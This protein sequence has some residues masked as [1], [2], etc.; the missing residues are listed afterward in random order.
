MPNSQIQFFQRLRPNVVQLWLCA[1]LG[2]VRARKDCADESMVFI[3][4]F[5]ATRLWSR[6]GFY[7]PKHAVYIGHKMTRGFN[8]NDKS[9]TWRCLCKRTLGLI[10]LEWVIAVC[11]LETRSPRIKGFIYLLNSPEY[12]P[13]NAFPHLTDR[14]MSLRN[15]APLSSYGL[16]DK[17]ASGSCYEPGTTEWELVLGLKM[18]DG[19]VRASEQR[20]SC[21]PPC[22]SIA[23]LP[24]PRATRA[25]YPHC[26][27]SPSQRENEGNPI[28][29][30]QKKEKE[31]QQWKPI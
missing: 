5:T 9:L 12:R 7:G 4:A 31:T 14:R 3:Y 19:D 26:V 28:A 11:T 24:L 27:V 20:I 22:V 15:P 10:G 17:Q 29:D 8:S 1:S 6:H 30:P 23:K 2:L 21:G 16:L 18:G 25:T 13:E